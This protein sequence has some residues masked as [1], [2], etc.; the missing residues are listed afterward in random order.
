[1]AKMNKIKE[2]WVEFGKKE[3]FISAEFWQFNAK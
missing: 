3:I 1:V 2:K